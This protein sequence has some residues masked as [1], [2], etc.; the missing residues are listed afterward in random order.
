MAAL[1]MLDAIRQLLHFEAVEAR[2]PQGGV[3]HPEHERIAAALETSFHTRDVTVASVVRQRFARAEEMLRTGQVSIRRAGQEDPGCANARGHTPAP[4]TIVLCGCE[5]PQHEAATLVHELA[6]AVMPRIGVRGRLTAPGQGVIDRSYIDHRVFHFLSPDEAL[7]NADS[8][9]LLVQNLYM[10]NQEIKPNSL[11]DTAPACS[12]KKQDQVLEAIARVQQWHDRLGAWFDSC[13]LSDLKPENRSFL[14]ANLPAA[15][16]PQGFRALAGFQRQF[17]HALTIRQVIACASKGG[18]CNNGVLAFS[19][20][21]A[22][23]RSATRRH[24]TS[25]SVSVCPAWFDLP[26]DERVSSLFALLVSFYAPKTGVLRDD[27]FYA[28]ARLAR[29]IAAPLLPPPVPAQEHLR[30][31]AETPPTSTA[32]DLRC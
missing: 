1:F 19:P 29:H 2:L 4:Q 21:I 26:S 15:A 28:Y 12:Q 9:S 24:Q 5:P 10:R 16:S 23:T 17:S 14:A 27:D 25:G 11:P 18:P 32:A 20:T 31:G 22:V 6:H 8:Y 13:G 30:R 7:D 3:P